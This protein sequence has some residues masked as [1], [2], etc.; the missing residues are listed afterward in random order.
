[1]SNKPNHRRGEIRRTEHGPRRFAVCDGLGGHDE[2][3]VAAQCVVDAL[4]NDV[5]A[6]LPADELIASLVARLRM[7]AW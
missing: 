3:D 5:I 1:M 7:H 4:Q 2:G 6:A